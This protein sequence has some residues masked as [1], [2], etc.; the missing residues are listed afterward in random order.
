MIERPCSKGWSQS[1]WGSP[2]ASSISLGCPGVRQT[3]DAVRVGVLRGGEATFREPEVAGHVVE[4]LLGDAPVA[5]LP[6]DEP[7]VKVR[8]GEQRVVVEHLLEVGDEPGLVHGV[9]VEASAELVVHAAGGHPVESRAHHV[10]RVVAPGAEQELEVRGRGELRGAPEAAVGGVELR[11]KRGHG[12]RRSAPRSAARSTAGAR[13]PPGSRRP[14]R[15]PAARAP[16]AAPRRP[17][18][19]RRGAA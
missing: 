11:A 3:F 16:C 7:G 4:R 12:V 2:S 8:R 5:L 6:G 15:R 14:G 13:S 17:A 10:E 19:R 18:K 1:G 9:A